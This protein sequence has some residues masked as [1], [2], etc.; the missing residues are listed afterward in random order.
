MRLIFVRHGEPDYEHDCLTELGRIQAADTAVRLEKENVKAVYSSPMGRAKETASY[1]AMK[2]GI[3]VRIL[4]YM[5]EIRWGNPEEDEVLR[6]G[7]PWTLS[8]RLLCEENPVDNSRNWTEH[9]YFKNNRC[10]EYYD[11]I[12]GNIDGL[13]GELGYE[14][15]DERYF[16]TKKNSD[17][18]ALFSHGG[19]GAC[20]LSHI[21]NMDF[22]Y[23]LSVLSY[24]LCSVT[25]INFPEDV[26][27]FVLPRI[28]LFN[29]MGHVKRRMDEKLY[30]DA[31]TILKNS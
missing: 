12:S 31:K 8:Y 26:N 20:A 18:V 22:A 30:F 10:R 21:L 1:T 28:E 14:R 27:E 2:N 6:E 13:L 16:C 29:D 4:E 25:I 5:H 9:P 24:G 7:H 19:S 15:R 17:T 3:P 11:M 23:V